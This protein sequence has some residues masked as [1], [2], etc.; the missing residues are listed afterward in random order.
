MTAI[1]QILYLFDEAF[2]G[3]AWHSLLGNLRSVTPDDWLWVPPDG[4][5]S[6][7]DIVQHVGGCKVMYNNHAFGDAQLTWDD[8]RVTDDAAV[9]TLDSA[10]EW[11]QASQERLRHNIASLDDDGLLQSRRAPNGTQKETRWIIKTMIE[12]DLYHAGEINHIRALCQH[13]D[14]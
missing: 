6:I 13:N 1:S 8:P 14:D 3:T 12:H 11:L 9:T 5:R 7:R 4:R 2:L 10:R